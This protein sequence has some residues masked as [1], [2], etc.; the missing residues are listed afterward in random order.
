MNQ[1]GK[2]IL[3]LTGLVT[4]SIHIINRVEYYLATVKDVLTC[5]DNN[6]YEWRFGKIRYVK[7]GKEIIRLQMNRRK[8]TA[9]N[10]RY[11]AALNTFSDT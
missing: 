11:A 1:K 2:T 6:Y 9:K 3:A 10:Q 5:P 7:K 4:V 8:P